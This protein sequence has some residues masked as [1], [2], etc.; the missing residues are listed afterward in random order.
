MLAIV[1]VAV[2]AAFHP[3]MHAV[4]HSFRRSARRQLRLADGST[5]SLDFQSVIDELESD[6]EADHRVATS[7]LL[8]GYWDVVYASEYPQWTQGARMVTH[9]IE[10]ANAMPGSSASPSTSGLHF[11]P[12]LPGLRN[13]PL[14]GN[15]WADVAGG[16][17]AYVQR[18]KRC[19][20]ALRAERRGTFTWLGGDDWD[21]EWVSG[22]WLLFG[23]PVW[24]WR[25][26]APRLP[27]DLDH[28]LR[29][30]YVDG[31]YLVLR[32]PAVVAGERILRPPRVYLLARQRNRLWQ[33]PTFVGLSDIM[34]FEP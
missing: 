2:A 8:D 26:R 12:G 3:C 23:V 32:S 1:A 19:Y 25:I 30:T 20:G 28:G 9:A 31:Q 4:H 18:A 24:Q 5:E 10:T 14:L 21:L 6:R 13:G 33:D 29:P 16:R 17:C 7:P 15:V 22:S 27:L 11:S 34:G